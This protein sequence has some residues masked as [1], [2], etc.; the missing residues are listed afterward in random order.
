[1]GRKCLISSL[2]VSWSHGVWESGP[3]L[4][5]PQAPP[6]P[7]VDTSPKGTEETQQPQMV[8]F[9]TLFI[10]CLLIFERERE[11]SIDFVLLIDAFISCFLYML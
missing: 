9:T 8:T 1:M 10:F 5:G 7:L 6:G 4:L 2:D 3:A 11:R